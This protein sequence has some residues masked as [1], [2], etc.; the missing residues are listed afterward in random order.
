MYLSWTSCHLKKETFRKWLKG[1]R[2]YLDKYARTPAD[3]PSVSRGCTHHNYVLRYTNLMYEL[4]RAPTAAIYLFL[5][6]EAFSSFCSFFI[7]SLN[8]N[9]AVAVSH[10]SVSFPVV[11]LYRFFLFFPVH[12]HCIFPSLRG[13]IVSWA[14]FII[15]MFLFLL[16]VA[17]QYYKIGL[18]LLALFLSLLQFQATIG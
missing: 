5:S 6:M 14:F 15:W 4:W 8:V 2:P 12:C 7:H 1:S 17:S 18:V 13:F 9:Y 16:Q 11:F 3:S 10:Y